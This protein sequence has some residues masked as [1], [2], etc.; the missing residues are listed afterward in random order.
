MA[1]ELT[2]V[3]VR[4]LG[5]LVEKRVTTPDYYPLT[6][7][8]LVSACNQKSNRDPV[9]SY[10][11]KT[12][13]RSLD[14]L[15]DRKLAIMWHTAGSRVPKYAE[16]MSGTFELED[17]QVAVLCMLMVR[18]PQTAG[19]LR[20]RTGR[21]HDFATTIEVEKTLTALVNREK[22]ALVVKLPRRPGAR[23][24][25]YMHLLAAEPDPATLEEPP[26]PVEA[27]RVQL[28]AEDQRIVTLEAEVC[29]LREELNALRETFAEF[30]QQFE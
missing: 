28:Q 27:A 23:E 30:R 6:L 16:E 19:E 20:T 26:P 24:G 14:T 3:Q 17:D 13:V 2:D 1:Y 11:D 21:L 18:G 12:I 29:S 5:A 8:A 7:N 22:G 25:R 9:V 10:D 15:R 4:V